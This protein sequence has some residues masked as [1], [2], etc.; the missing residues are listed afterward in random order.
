[1]FQQHC[2]LWGEYIHHSEPK[3]HTPSGQ[4]MFKQEIIKLD[5]IPYAKEVLNCVPTANSEL[6]LKEEGETKS[7][8][9]AKLSC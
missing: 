6:F 2:W 7:K 1:M 9:G 4:S 8:Q 5:L 3:Q